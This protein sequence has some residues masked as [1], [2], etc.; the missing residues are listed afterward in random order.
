MLLS[1]HLAD[2]SSV[3]P[4]S[5][6]KKKR[7]QTHIAALKIWDFTKKS[8][9]FSEE[10]LFKLTQGQ[11]DLRISERNRQYVLHIIHMT[12]MRQMEHLR[13]G[14]ETVEAHVLSPKFKKTTNHLVQKKASR[15]TKNAI[16][17]GRP[18]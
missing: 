7:Q 8:D 11:R 12:S 17:D 4:L 3:L 9:I 13:I 14:S 18:E 5:I 10:F 15:Y 1:C 6:K 16:V 2:K